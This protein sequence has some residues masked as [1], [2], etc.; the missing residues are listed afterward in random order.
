MS[1]DERSSVAT[2]RTISE[3][4]G[5]GVG[6]GLGRS[7]GP[8][9]SVKVIVVSSGT[10]SVPAGDRFRSRG[11]DK[12]ELTLPEVFAHAREVAPALIDDHTPAP[13]GMDANVGAGYVDLGCQLGRFL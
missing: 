2:P 4:G 8:R 3:A 12:D 11:N 1:R 6:E 5:L 9:S 10:I 7:T 13:A